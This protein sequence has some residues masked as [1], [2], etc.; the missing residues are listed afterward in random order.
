MDVDMQDEDGLH[1]QRLRDDRKEHTAV[2]DLKTGD[3]VT[4]KDGERSR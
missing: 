4:V 2:R 3:I 1:T